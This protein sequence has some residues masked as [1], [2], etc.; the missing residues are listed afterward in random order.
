M[1]DLM[2]T[3]ILRKTSLRGP[4]RGMAAD[5][6]FWSA[7]TSSRRRLLLAT[8]GTVLDQEVHAIAVD[9]VSATPTDPDSFLESHTESFL[10]SV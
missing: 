4:I 9:P 1:G 5:D 3:S 8:W 10:S 6:C 2:S 7:K